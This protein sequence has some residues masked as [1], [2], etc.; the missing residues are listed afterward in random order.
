MF[1]GADTGPGARAITH[2][3]FDLPQQPDSTAE[4]LI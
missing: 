1:A 4:L 3:G 2:P